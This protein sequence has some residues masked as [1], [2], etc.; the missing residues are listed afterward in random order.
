[1][2]SV[3]T[4]LATGIDSEGL[5]VAL[6]VEQADKTRSALRLRGVTEANLAMPMVDPASHTANCIDWGMRPVIRW[7]H[8]LS[9]A[10]AGIGNEPPAGHLLLVGD[11]PALSSHYAGGHGKR[12]YWNVLNGESV[13]PGQADWVVITEWELGVSSGDCD[14][15]LLC[16]YPKNYGKVP[17]P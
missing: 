13:T 10:P 17:K 5:D 8:P 9:L 11:K 3:L 12:M 6:C 7:K 1:M 2:D 16:V 4:P 14:F 15:L